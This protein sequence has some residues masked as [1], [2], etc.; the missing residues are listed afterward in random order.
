MQQGGRLF[1][2]RSTRAMEYFE[3]FENLHIGKD[4]MFQYATGVGRQ[5]LGMTYV[6]ENPEGKLTY[7]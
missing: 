6:P 7:R 3:T 4:E 2:P 5:A 1:T